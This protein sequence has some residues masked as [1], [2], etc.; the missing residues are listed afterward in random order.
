MIEHI[1][2]HAANTV[3][4]HFRFTTIGIKHPHAGVGHIRRLDQYEPIT[5]YAKSS[6]GNLNRQCVCRERQLFLEAVDV[7]IV[8]ARAMHFSKFHIPYLADSLYGS[9]L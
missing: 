4:A 2:S 8:V 7:N 9:A 3:A 5:A 1:F 6:I